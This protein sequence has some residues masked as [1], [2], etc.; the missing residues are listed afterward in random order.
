MKKIKIKTLILWGVLLILGI[1]TW[2]SQTCYDGELSGIDA[3]ISIHV[4]DI[5]GRTR[6]LVGYKLYRNDR[7]CESKG[8]QPAISNEKG[9]LKIIVP[10]QR[11]GG[12][13]T[14]WEEMLGR[15]EETFTTVYE[16]RYKTT[17]LFTIYPTFGVDEKV[18][19]NCVFRDSF[20]E[21]GPE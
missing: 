6:P 5:N 12:T 3:D 18:K 11:T 21:D 1:G 4:K 14:I 7:L 8:E 2:L 16:I 20:P 17:T 19:I 10:P 15:V 9:E 13:F